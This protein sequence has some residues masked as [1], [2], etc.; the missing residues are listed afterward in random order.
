MNLASIRSKVASILNRNDATDALLN[1]F[2]TM[3]QT[4]IE[5]TLRVPGMEKIS[6]TTGNDPAVTPTNSIVIPSDFLSLKYLYSGCTLMENK[7]LGHFLPLLQ[8]GAGD[9][10]YYSRVGASFLVKPTVP[11][12]QTVQ[13]VYYASQPSLLVDTDTNFF[14]VVA[15]DLLIYA[16]LSYAAD[17]FVD[18]RAPTFE[19]RFA[20]LYADLEEQGRMTD[21][22]QSAQAIA[23]AYCQ[24][25]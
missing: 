7:D 6:L 1:D 8:A 19:S 10:R 12:G 22:E 17:Y 14:T 24:D 3:A 2:I 18:D 9:P 25:Y 5:R 11:Q 20:Q 21:M 15:A 13:M 23:P 4:R 16:A